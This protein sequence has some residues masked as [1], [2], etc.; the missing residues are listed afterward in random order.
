MLNQ[1]TSSPM[2]TSMFGGRCCACCCVRCCCC[3]ATGAFEMPTATS[4]SEASHFRIETSL[5]SWMK[6]DNDNPPRDCFIAGD[7]FFTAESPQQHARSDICY[8]NHPRSGAVSF[9][10]HPL[11][12][13]IV[14]RHSCP[15]FQTAEE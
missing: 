7:Y 14:G 3:A 2:M 5:C 13:L 15:S 10:P 9:G 8:A 11:R 6:S 1:P 4:A 12:F